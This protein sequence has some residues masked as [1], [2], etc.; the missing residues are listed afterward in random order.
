MLKLFG[1]IKMDFD[2]TYHHP[3]T[4]SALVRYC[5]QSG[6][7]AAPCT[8]CSQA[9]KEPATW[10]TRLHE[11]SRQCRSHLKIRGKRRCGGKRAPVQKAM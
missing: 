7:A 8:N 1:I 4:H 2:P 9:S 3:I 5:K 11:S 10:E 6:S